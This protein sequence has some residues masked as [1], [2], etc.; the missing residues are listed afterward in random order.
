[1]SSKDR[2][3]TLC[4]GVLSPPLCLIP[5]FQT[6]GFDRHFWLYMA[7]IFGAWFGNSANSAFFSIF[8]QEQFGFRSVSGMYALG[9]VA[10]IPVFFFSTFLIRRVG[11]QRMFFVSLSTIILRLLVYAL[12]PN[13]WAIV[14]T[15][16]F[17]AL[18][19]A[20]LHTA[21]VAYINLKVNKSRQALGMA[22]YMAVGLGLSG[23]LGSSVGRFILERTGFQTLFLL[24]AGPP[25]LSFLIIF[26]NKEKLKLIQ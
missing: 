10:A 18:T 5:R 25:A 14:V 1:M 11:I 23:F 21:S 26:F 7:I 9:A 12:I 15:R 13:I 6:G 17:S 2:R 3:R 22:I 16:L 20:L 19:F 24:Y 8:L 4:C